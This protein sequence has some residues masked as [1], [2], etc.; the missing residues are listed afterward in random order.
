MQAFKI[1]SVVV[2]KLR[3]NSGVTMA[4]GILRP[5]RVPASVLERVPV[6]DTLQFTRPIMPVFPTARQ[7]AE[8]SGM[9]IPEALQKA[10]DE[11]IPQIRTNSTERLVVHNL[12]T[13]EEIARSASGDEIATSLD[14]RGQLKLIEASEK[15]IKVSMIHNHPYEI[16]L[17]PDD[18]L[19]GPSK[20]TNY[21]TVAMVS[22]GGGYAIMQRTRD[23][24]QKELTDAIENFWIP[25]CNFEIFITRKMQRQGE[26]NV[27]I[28]QELNKFREKHAPQVAEAFGYK[29]YYKPGELNPAHVPAKPFEAD[30]KPLIDEMRGEDELCKRID[31]I[32][33]EEFYKP[34]SAK[35]FKDLIGFQ[36]KVAQK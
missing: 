32:P 24:S 23:L 7:M 33:I 25:L 29:Y 14:F 17:S 18:L 20:M 31:E 16:S 21:H 8:E 6:S 36:D 26:T 9:N 5:T 10:W 3:Q 4:M 35:R 11:V 13:G 28:L 15:D 27:E 22:R 34:L 19:S 1:L 30:L 2:S 12:E